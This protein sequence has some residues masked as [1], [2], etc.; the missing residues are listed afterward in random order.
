MRVCIDD[1][2]IRGITDDD[3]GAFKYL[4]YI[5]SYH[6]RYTL[7]ID[8]NLPTDCEKYLTQSE[9]EF[10]KSASINAINNLQYDCTIS[11]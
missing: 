8:S 11:R 1:D 2:I 7:C 10:F 3:Y 4:M 9:I 5:C 6:N